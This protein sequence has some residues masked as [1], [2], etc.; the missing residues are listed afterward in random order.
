M[1]TFFG[2]TRHM[3]PPRRD[4]LLAAAAQLL[5]KGGPD[6]VKLREVGS[7]SGVSHNA[8]YKHFASKEDLLAAL[9]ARELSAVCNSAEQNAADQVPSAKM[10]MLI[11]LRWGLAYPERFR[12]VSGRWTKGSS[13]ELA[14][15]ANRWQSLL[16]KSVAAGQ[17]SGELPEGDPERLSFLILSVAHGAANLALSGHLSAKGKGKAD[18]QDLVAD[19]FSYL[20]RPGFESPAKLHAR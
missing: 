4:Q 12:L 20:A 7:A 16:Y 10:I 1:S 8:P 15:A 14:Q 9:A 5:D 11:Y 13:Q 19:L 6:A 18:P 17:E 3:D 2:N